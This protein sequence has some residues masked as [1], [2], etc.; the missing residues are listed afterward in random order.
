MDYFTPLKANNF[1]IEKL[2][3][4]IGF[5][6]NTI[7]VVTDHAREWGIS[8]LCALLEKQ[9]WTQNHVLQIL[10]YVNYRITVNELPFPIHLSSLS[11]IG[12]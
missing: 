1:L 12:F 10:T 6:C 2:N 8:L 11:E 7:K 3:S 4:K 5:I 9:T